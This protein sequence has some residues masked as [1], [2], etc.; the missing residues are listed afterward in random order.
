[1]TDNDLQVEITTRDDNDTGKQLSL[2]ASLICFCSLVLTS[3][4]IAM[5]VD[6]ST[7]TTKPR[8]SGRVIAKSKHK[9]SK[10][11]FQKYSDRVGKKKQKS[12]K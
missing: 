11:V 12:Q 10:M 2:F 8:R 9:K 7:K 3:R 6:A 1:M 4:T 5:E